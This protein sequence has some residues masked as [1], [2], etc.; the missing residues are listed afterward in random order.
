MFIDNFNGDNSFKIKDLLGNNI[1]NILYSN[2]DSM[3]L[4]EEFNK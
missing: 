4:D 2:K 1:I 3:K